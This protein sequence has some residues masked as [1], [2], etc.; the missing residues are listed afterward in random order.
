MICDFYIEVMKVPH[1][2]FSFIMRQGV[3]DVKTPA[4][5]EL[6]KNHRVFL[7]HHWIWTGVKTAWLTFTQ[8]HCI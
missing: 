2:V 1:P 8:L 4:N 7:L 6:A 3:L 5:I